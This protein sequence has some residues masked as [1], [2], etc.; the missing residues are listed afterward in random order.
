MLGK[1]L[2]KYLVTKKAENVVLSNKWS[3]IINIEVDNNTVFNHIDKTTIVNKLRSFQFKFVHRILHF[4]D[5]LFKCKLVST[6][7]CDF[8][9]Q[10]LDS[11]DHRYFYCN[12]TQEFWTQ[13]TIWIQA[14]Y[15]RV[16]NVN[17][18]HNLITNM[19]N[20]MPLIETIMLNAKYYIYSC[21]LKKEKPNINTFKHVVKEIEKTE[22]YIANQKNLLHV[23]DT[24]WSNMN[25][26][27]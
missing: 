3:H 5:R 19:Y 20:D 15:N 7:L 9:C 24:K 2:Y 14:E 25:L 17:N 10:A 26:E 12:T 21:F 1:R 11:I 27:P 8:C 6:T 13:L 16:C 22:R 18:I 23:H 4:N